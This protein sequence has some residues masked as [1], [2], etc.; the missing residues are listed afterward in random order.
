[1]ETLTTEQVSIKDVESASLALSDKNPQNRLKAIR[2]LTEISK[3]DPIEQRQH[4]VESA[5]KL[6]DDKEPFI[7]WNVATALGQIGHE[8]ALPILEKMVNDQHANVKFR[9]LLAF[10]LIGS[11]KAVPII[12]NLINDEYKIKDSYV[13]RQFVPIALGQI[14]H[15]SG[16]PVLAKLVEDTDPVVRW[17]VAVALGDIGHVSGVEIL[18]KLLNDEIPFVRAHTAI[19]LS[20]IGDKSGYPYFEQLI[21]DEVERVANISKAS[22]ETLNTVV[23]CCEPGCSPETCS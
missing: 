3:H 22:L 8:N 21:K 4:Y 1:M 2:V 7:R 16:V 12:E 20:E 19:A 11:P 18:V 15:E 6:W 13:V 17:H 10:G 14:G 5:G 23:T 9:A